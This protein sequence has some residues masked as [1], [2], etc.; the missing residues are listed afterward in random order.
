MTWMD[1]FGGFLEKIG[2][3]GIG[4]WIRRLFPGESLRDS[5]QGLLVREGSRSRYFGERRFYR[6]NITRLGQLARG[7]AENDLGC[8]GIGPRSGWG[9]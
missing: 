5:S 9:E 6:V 4:F 1:D 2:R 8:D 3:A 7:F